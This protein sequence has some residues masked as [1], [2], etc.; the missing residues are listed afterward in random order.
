MRGRKR[1][2]AAIREAEGNRSRRPIPDEVKGEGRP[3]AAPHLSVE[4][5]DAFYKIVRSMP[6]GLF[7]EADTAAIELWAQYLVEYRDCQKQITTTGRL[8]KGTNG[9]EA[10]PLI[11]IRD[12]AAR[13]L[14]K[15]GE[16][17][18]L[19]PVARTRLTAPDAWK[20][21]PMALLLGGMADGALLTGPT[22][23]Q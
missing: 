19:S 9:P 11:P 5:R 8:V 15:L 23:K 2:P 20:D 12:N 21:D 3:L 18:G 6:V 22:A 7:C 14:H 17:L 13:M 16:A 10:H 4:E 1:K